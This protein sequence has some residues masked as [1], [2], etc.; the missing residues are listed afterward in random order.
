MAPEDKYKAVFIMHWDTYCDKV[1]PFD[2]E[3]VRATYQKMIITLLYG[4]MN[5]EV[6]VYI[7]NIIVKSKAKAEHV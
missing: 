6:K 5:K 3:N 4:M 1:M 2:L 7:D